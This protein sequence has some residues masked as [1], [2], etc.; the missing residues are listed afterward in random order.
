MANVTPNVTLCDVYMT[1]VSVAMPHIESFTR[2]DILHIILLFCLS[3]IYSISSTS[4]FS[5]LENIVDI[6]TVFKDN[7]YESIMAASYA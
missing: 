5:T 3:I 7:N 1:M 2:K 6:I 4:M